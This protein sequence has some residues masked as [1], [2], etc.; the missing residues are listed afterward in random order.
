VRLKILI[1]VAAIL[2][3]VVAVFAVLVAMRPSELRIQRSATIAAPAPA[4]FAQVNDFHNWE[5]WSPWAKLDPSAANSFD[6]APAGTGASFAWAG[7]SNMGEGRMTIVESRPSELVRIELQFLKPFAATN[8]AE[9]TFKPEGE[10]T[11]VTWSM[12]GHNNFVAR[13]VGLVMNMDSPAA[14]SRRA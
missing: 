12:Y 5:A 11:A 14:S 4:V 7:N 1:A 6:G 8:T 10:Q 13:A 2:V 9:F 3:L